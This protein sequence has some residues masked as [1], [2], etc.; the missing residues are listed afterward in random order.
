M[1]KV[2]TCNLVARR[3]TGSPVALS[4]ER[5]GVTREYR[6]T[7]NDA[8]FE[9]L[10]GSSVNLKRSITRVAQRLASRVDG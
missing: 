8:S 6:A 3:L 5:T 2:Y 9:W 7:F 1:G 4:V 10:G